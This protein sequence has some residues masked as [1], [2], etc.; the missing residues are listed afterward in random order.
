MCGRVLRSMLNSWLCEVVKY[1]N[2]LA[3]DQIEHFHRSV[4]LLPMLSTLCKSQYKHCGKA[5]EVLSVLM[6]FN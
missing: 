1:E 3:A 6:M 4:I 2:Q 5:V